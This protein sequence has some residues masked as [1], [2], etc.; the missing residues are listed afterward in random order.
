MKDFIVINF[1]LENQWPSKSLKNLIKDIITWDREHFGEPLSVN[2]IPCC[3]Y[4]C[5][6]IQSDSHMSTTSWYAAVFSG[7]ELIW[8]RLM[9]SGKCG[10]SGTREAEW[11]GCST[12]AALPISRLRCFQ[13]HIL[14][15]CNTRSF[16]TSWLPYIS[17][18]KTHQPKLSTAQLAVSQPQAGA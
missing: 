16:V 8:D 6:L 15:R 7:P 4:K 18:F 11:T 14:F 9:Q 17:C 1:E 3:I 2:T 13:K 12:A 5:M 10:Y